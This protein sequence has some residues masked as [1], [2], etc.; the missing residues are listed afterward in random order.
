MNK[1][2]SLVYIIFLLLLALT[3]FLGLALGSVNLGIEAIYQGINDPSS[4]AYIIIM[5]L[6]LP[7]VCA[8]AL[9]GFALAVA[10]ATLQNVTNNHLCAPNI[11]GINAG[12]GFVVMVML[13]FMSELWLWLPIG[14]FV[15]A[16]A[17]TFVV[18][19]LAFYGGNRTQGTTIVLAGVAISSILN[20]V[21]SFLSLRYPDVLTSYTAFSVGGFADVALVRLLFPAIIIMVAFGVLQYLSAKLNIL[22][23]GD[24]MAQSLG[25]NVKRVRMIALVASAALCAAAVSFA[26]LLGFVGLIVPHIARY[27]SQH[28]MRYQLGLSGLAGAALTILSDLG[29]RLLFAPS[30]LPAG[31]IMALIGAPFFLYLL[32]SRRHRYGRM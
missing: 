18:M 29:G 11:I 15:G 2:I 10:G 19:S 13:C 28:D 9:A 26:G 1:K 5:Q 4:T 27:F 8:A 25:V 30:E 31:I 20:A 7:R 22:C 16:L 17:T 23:L 24:E 3:A 21:I 12:A 6:R 32:I 14:A